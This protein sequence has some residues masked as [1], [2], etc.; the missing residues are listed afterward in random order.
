MYMCKAFSGILFAF[1]VFSSS[2]DPH[3]IKENIIK[4]YKHSDKIM[5]VW[6]LETTQGRARSGYHM[7]CRAVGKSNEFGYGVHLGMCFDSFR[8]SVSAVNAFFEL[9]ERK[10]ICLYNTGERQKDCEYLRNYKVL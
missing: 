9:E 3:N 6:T 7:D 10:A 2:Q 8:D 1:C 4:Q 5:R